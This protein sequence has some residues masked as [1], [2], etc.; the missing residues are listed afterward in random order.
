L[1]ILTVT[2][3]LGA[4]VA[5]SVASA[6]WMMRT[7]RSKHLVFRTAPAKSRNHLHHHT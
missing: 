7:F 2:I 1:S 4:R 3:L 5:A 6:Q